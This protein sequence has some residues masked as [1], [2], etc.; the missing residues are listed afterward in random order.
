MSIEISNA[1]QEIEEIIEKCIKCGMCKSHCCVLR[2][3]REECVSPRGRVS[4]FENNYFE[5]MIYDCTLCGACE[6]D[7]PLGLKLCDAFI[8]ARKV[9]VGQKREVGENKE[10]IKNLNKSGNVFGEKE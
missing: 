3:V 4:L 7:C 2:V 9:L 10:M 1:K 8:N 6:K 5:K